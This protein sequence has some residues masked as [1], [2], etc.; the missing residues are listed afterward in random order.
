VQILE[1]IRNWKGKPKE[2]VIF[3]SEKV[4]KDKKLF[5]QLADGLKNGSKVE[6][7]VCAEVMEYVTKDEPEFALPYI[8]TIIDYIDYDAPRVKWETSRVIGNVTQKFPNKVS[9]A[10]SKL[11]LNTKDKGTVV[12]WSAAYGLTEIAKNNPKSQN[13]LI[14]KFSEIIKKE[15]NNGVKNVY[16]KALKVIEK[17]K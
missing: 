16:L 5:N 10:I 11:M 12:R 13:E 4:K 6:K 17:E 9:K 8:D 14:S 3:L 1:E 15:E 7:G 2:L